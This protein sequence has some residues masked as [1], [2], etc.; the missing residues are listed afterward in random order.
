VY[1]F[2]DFMNMFIMFE[3]SGCRVEI[4]FRYGTIPHVPYVRR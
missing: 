4:E 1:V 3:L 2:I